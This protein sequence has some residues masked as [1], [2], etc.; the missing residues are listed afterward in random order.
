M[1]DDY[2]F[3]VSTSDL[4]KR[5]KV[6][7]KTARAILKCYDIHPFIL[8]AAQRF[9]WTEVAQVVE[10]LTIDEARQV[11]FETP[12]LTYSEVADVLCVSSQ[13]VRNYCRTGRINCVKMSSHVHRFHKHRLFEW[14][15]D[16]KNGA[17]AK[18]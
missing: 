18:M 12:L 7:R 16:H 13:S 2:L 6:D 11:S 14:E 10:R 17:F 15:S 3:F 9:L 4:A 5:W 8:H 1:L